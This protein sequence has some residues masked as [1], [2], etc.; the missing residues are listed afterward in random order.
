MLA[1]I[2]VLSEDIFTLDPSELASV[3]V[4]YTIFDGRVVYPI[5][6]KRLTLP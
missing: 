2:V 4:A 1:D 5:H 3:K 6:Q